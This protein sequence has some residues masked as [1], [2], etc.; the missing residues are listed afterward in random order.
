MKVLGLNLSHNA[1]CAIVENAELIF[2]I[3]EER[4]S[5]KKKDDSIE[6]I[7]EN[8][9]NQ[10]FDIIAYTS[11]DLNI[12][13]NKIYKEKVNRILKKNNITFIELIP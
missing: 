9:K 4:L 12:N 13:V 6:F 8:L 7:C 3:E 10:H 11:Y 2:S 1:S 5:K